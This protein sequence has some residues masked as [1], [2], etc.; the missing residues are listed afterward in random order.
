MCI[1]QVNSFKHPYSAI[2]VFFFD[3]VIRQDGQFFKNSLGIESQLRFIQF[4]FFENFTLIFIDFSKNE[5][6]S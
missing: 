5:I 4:G 3:N 2:K 1:L 6:W